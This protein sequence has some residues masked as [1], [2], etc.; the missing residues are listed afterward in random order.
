MPDGNAAVRPEGR[1]GVAGLPDVYGVRFEDGEP[2]RKSEAQWATRI[3]ASYAQRTR[4]YSRE[5]TSQCLLDH[6]QSH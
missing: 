5:A 1:P 6:G 2:W 3:N 4:Q